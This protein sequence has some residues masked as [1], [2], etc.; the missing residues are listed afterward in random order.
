MILV[1]GFTGT[2][3]I[4]KIFEDKNSKEAVLYYKELSAQGMVVQYTN[5]KEK[6]LDEYLCS[7]KEKI[8][9]LHK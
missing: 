4:E 3:V 2:G 7:V 5:M 9:E 1:K 6:S 8:E